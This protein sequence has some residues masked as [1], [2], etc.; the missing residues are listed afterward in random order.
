VT[1]VDRYLFI[2][3]V[4]ANGYE[5]YEVSNYAKTG[6]PIQKTRPLTTVR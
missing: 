4:Q 3:I 2:Y 6:T 1:V 5:H